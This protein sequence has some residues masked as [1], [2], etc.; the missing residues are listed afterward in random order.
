VVWIVSICVELI[1]EKGNEVR[2]LSH[3]DVARAMERAVRRA[4]LP[5][6]Y[7]RGYNPRPKLAFASPLPLG[8]CG[9]AERAALALSRPMAAREVFAA[10]APCMP[11]GLRLK[12]VVALPNGRKPAYHLLDRAD[13]VVSFPAPL[14]PPLGQRVAE[15]LA[16]PTLPVARRKG[17]GW[18]TVDIRR[19]IISARATS[20]TEL[21]LTLACGP[22][23]HASPI[24]VLRAL[25]AYSDDQ[26][27]PRIVRTRLYRRA[28]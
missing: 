21:E 8:V 7:S 19:Y 9:S 10:L 3:L 14:D 5:V 28:G 12:D 24:E 6:A 13:Y 15:L 4:K 20:D 23:G 25:E 1:F 22:G 18:K 27:M 17:Q 2:F 11:P 26:P 16:R